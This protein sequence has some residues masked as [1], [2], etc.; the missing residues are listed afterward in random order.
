M[1]SS[2]NIVRYNTM[3][4]TAGQFTLRHGNRTQ[5][6]GN[7]ILG[8]GRGNTG[9]RV[10]GGGHKIYNNYINVSGAGI[11]IDS[12]SSNDTSGA[13]TD[14]KQTYDIEVVFNTVV[15]GSINIGS[16]KPLAPRNI[17]VGYN[18][19]QGNVNAVGGAQVKSMGN[20]VSGTAAL[21]GGVMKAEPGLTKMGDIFR[22]TMG[23]PAI[24]AADAMFP[25]V[26]D[27]ADGRPRSGKFDVGAE[28]L[29][30]G[31]AKFGLLTEKDVG[32]MAP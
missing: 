21:S 11:L 30:N 32:P 22:L 31:M 9:F 8:D 14:H 2:D 27:D 29:G 5:V 19:V 23:S 13:L 10:Y 18:L 6:Y 28:E 26:M 20:I 7:Y 25:Y 17:T 4:A 16:G 1:K 24:D 15:G 3:R 12:G